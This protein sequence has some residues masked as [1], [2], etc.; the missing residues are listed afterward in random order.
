[1]LLLP[2]DRQ[3][4]WRNP[5]VVTLLLI[6]INIGCF[7]FW[8]SGED[9]A[10]SRAMAYYGSSGLAE[11]EYPYFEQYLRARG[12]LSELPKMALVRKQPEQLYFGMEAE[13]AFVEQ[14]RAGRIIR[15]SNE[16]FKVWQEQRA[17]L[18]DLLSDV[19]YLNYGWRAGDPHLANLFAHMF[20]H[21]DFMHLFGNMFFLLAVGLLVEGVLAR[22]I[23]LSCYLLG[24]LGAA[25]FELLVTPNDLM[26]GIGASGAVSALMGT[27]AML[28]WNRTVRVFFFLF[29]YFD[30]I[31]V[32]AIILLPV[33]VG[34]ELFQMWTTPDSNIN[35]L[36]H[37]GGFASG[38][39]L[40]WLAKDSRFYD[41]GFVDAVDN[42]SHFDERLQRACA[43]CDQQDFKTAL[44]LLRTLHREK[45][46]DTK[47]LYHLFSAERLYPDGAG[48]HDVASKILNLPSADASTSAMVHDVYQNYMRLAKPKPRIDRQLA[49]RLVRRFESSGHRA[50][51]ETLQGL[52]DKQ[53]ARCDEA[54]S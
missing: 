44:P 29:V 32:P 7:V 39:V 24:G 30:Y 37:L 11:V 46:A 50:T 36:A 41:A 51:A 34:N 43:A 19:T 33:W 54:V 10:M 21:A 20:L 6:A 53:G 52:L 49:C 5:P 4:D 14:L 31:R 23:Y 9:E 22:W 28:F 47:V 16:Q 15:S 27:Y 2:F 1:M 8:Q 25:G 17:K 12:R 42:D 35:F 18:D 45:P 13:R 26:P 38:A 40:G 48:F 3:F